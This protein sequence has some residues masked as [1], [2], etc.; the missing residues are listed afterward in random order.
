MAEQILFYALSVAAVVFALLVITHRNA[1]YSALFLIGAFFCLAGLY[2]MLNAQFIAA[3][4]VIVYAGAVMV[5]FIFVIMLLSSGDATP[6]EP[7]S[8][9]RL[10]GFVFAV[11]L[12][13]QVV[14][15]LRMGR[16][17]TG[18]EGPYTQEFVRRVGSTESV[19][20]SLFTTYLYPFE[21]VSV[22]LLLAIIGAVVLG[23]KKT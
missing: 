21:V 3:V 19:G 14:M 18:E 6:K 23:R 15:M 12:G 9:R 4:Q 20:L 1:V 7:I 17:T 10:V 16:M 22:L 2:V 13:L 11:L 5:L 8:L